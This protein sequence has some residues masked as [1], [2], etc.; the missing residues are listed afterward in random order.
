MRL[1][2]LVCSPM[3]VSALALQRGG[4]FLF[5]VCRLL[6]WPEKKMMKPGRNRASLR[7]GGACTCTLCRAPAQEGRLEGA[8]G[9]VGLQWALKGKKLSLLASL[10]SQ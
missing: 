10:G 5:V 1:S 6:T 2:F 8:V 4:S 9:Y 3:G 7:L